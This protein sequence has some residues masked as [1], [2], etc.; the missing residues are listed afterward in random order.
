MIKASNLGSDVVKL[1][2][3]SLGGPG[4][5]KAL[6]GPFPDLLL[7]PTGGVSKDNLNEWF[8]AGAFAV[9]AGSNLCPKDL[10]IAGEFD[11]I[12]QIAG[13]FINAIKKTRY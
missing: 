8:A 10:A 11:Q 3:G 13:E 2:P 6:K 1:F 12:T 5:L 7:M 9:G 4:Y